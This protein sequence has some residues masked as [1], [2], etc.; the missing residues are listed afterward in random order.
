MKLEDFE[1]K[2]PADNAFRVRSV[3]TAVSLLK[4]FH[5]HFNSLPSAYYIFEPA[6]QLINFLETSTLPSEL[7]LE[8]KTLKEGIDTM[9]NNKYRHLSKEKKRPKA[10]KLYEP[11][12]ER[13]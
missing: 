8:M 1:E 12:I 10:L 2:I 11:N 7:K 5:L 3:W 13:V 9:K 4:E 6:S